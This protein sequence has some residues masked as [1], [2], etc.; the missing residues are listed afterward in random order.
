MLASLPR[1]AARVIPRNELVNQNF[2]K[3]FPEPLRATQTKVTTL[4]LLLKQK[5]E[6]GSSY[7]PNIRIEPPLEKQKLAKVPADI[8][9]ELKEYLKER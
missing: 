6:A 1:L 3:L 2:S 4:D 8:R 9:R 7:P 5:A